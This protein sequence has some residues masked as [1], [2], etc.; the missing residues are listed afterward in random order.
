MEKYVEYVHQKLVPHH[1]LI[2]VISQK[3]IQCNHETLLE[4]ILK[5]DYRKSSKFS[6]SFFVFEPILF[7]WKLLGKTRRA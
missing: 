6:K 7:L 4:D 5:E 2:W 3:Y 1:Y